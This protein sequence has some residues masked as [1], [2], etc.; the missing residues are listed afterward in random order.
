MISRPKNPRP[1]GEGVAVGPAVGAAGLDEAAVGGRTAVGGRIGSGAT[2]EGVAAEEVAAVGG[3]SGS[4]AT[5]GEAAGS[6]WAASV[7]GERPQKQ[8]LAPSISESWL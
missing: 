4:G 5:A 3:R 2:A 7:L 6:G 8:T 1:I